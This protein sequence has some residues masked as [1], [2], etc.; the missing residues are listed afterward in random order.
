MWR[1]LSF[2]GAPQKDSKPMIQKIRDPLMEPAN[3]RKL[4]IS[5]VK[6]YMKHNKKDFRTNQQAIKYIRDTS[7]TKF[8]EVE[9]TDLRQVL[10]IPPMLYRAIQTPLPAWFSDTKNIDWFV[11][12]FPQFSTTDSKRSGLIAIK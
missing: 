8:N 2:W 12:N 1:P 11:E 9:G 5:Y 3:Q 10:E 7:A 4:V 6:Y